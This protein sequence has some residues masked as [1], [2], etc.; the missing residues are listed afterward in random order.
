MEKALGIK[1]YVNRRSNGYTWTA[2]PTAYAM[3][4]YADDFVVMC[5]TKQQ[6]E[7]VYNKLNP[8]LAQRGLEL[9]KTK[10]VEVTQGFD[11]LS[12]NIRR[13]KTAK[14]E[15]LFIKPSKDSIKNSKRKISDI[16]HQVRE[17]KV[18]MLIQKLNPVMLGMANYWKPEVSSRAFADM[19]KH[20]VNVTYR[21]LRRTHR[22][23]NNKSQCDSPFYLLYPKFRKNL[24]ADLPPLIWAF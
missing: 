10:I 17:H 3:T 20:I 5:N 2:N 19:D 18:D 9:E 23:K 13:Y 12:F 24:V 21:F 7:S 16:T 14:G 22:K 8:Y 11:F 4:R 1:Y 15:Q 6:A